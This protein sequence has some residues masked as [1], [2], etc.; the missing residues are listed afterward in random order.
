MELCPQ[1]ENMVYK[2]GGGFC[3]APATLVASINGN[4]VY[5]SGDIIAKE[6]FAKI[7]HLKGEIIY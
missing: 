3:V 6:D 2:M 7:Y 4:I 5:L 1:R